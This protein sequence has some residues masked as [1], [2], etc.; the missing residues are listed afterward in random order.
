MDEQVDVPVNEL[1]LALKALERRVQA[2]AASAP[3]SPVVQDIQKAVATIRR[4]PEYRAYVRTGTAV[5]LRKLI[6][7]LHGVLDARS[8]WVALDQLNRADR[9]GFQAVAEFLE[10]FERLLAERS[11]RLATNW[12][13]DVLAYGAAIMVHTL[14]DR[15]SMILRGE[16]TADEG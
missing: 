11:A 14:K 13:K 6:D 10:D 2:L 16:V 9:E 7:R 8:R 15:I 3:S 1:D 12:A 4:T 5:E